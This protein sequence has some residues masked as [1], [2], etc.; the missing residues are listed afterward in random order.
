MPTRAAKRA[1]KF[2]RKMEDFDRQVFNAL[3]NT[4]CEEH[5]SNLP[6][7]KL[8]NSNLTA[9][10]YCWWLYTNGHAGKATS[11]LP[12]DLVNKDERHLKSIQKERDNYGVPSTYR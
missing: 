1:A 11:L 9:W 12:K 6:H 5:L 4:A 2:N 7:P 3:R 8:P 10:D